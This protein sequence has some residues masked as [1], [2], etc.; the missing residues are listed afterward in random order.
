MFAKRTTLGILMMGLAA[1]AAAQIEPG[2][3]ARETAKDYRELA[4]YPESSRVLKRGE[5]DP[6]RAKRL[7]T[8]QSM[9]GPDGS[10]PILS[11]WTAKISFEVGQ[12]IDLFATLE[13]RAKAVRPDSISGEIADASGAIVAQVTYKDDGQEADRT[14]GDGVWSARLAMPKGLEPSPAASYMVRVKARL[15]DGDLRDGA[16]GFLYSRPSAHLTGRYRDLLRDGNLVVAAEVDVKE[17]GRFHLAG[18][19][20]TAEGEPIGTA[21]SAAHLEPG[22]YWIELS[23]YGLMFHDRKAAGPYRL[24]SLALSTTN[25]MPNAQND[26]VENVHLTRAYRTGQMTERPF[27]E[28]R[29]LETAKRLELDADRAQ[30]RTAPEQQ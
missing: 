23:Y 19:L 18:T 26:L 5:E 24:A 15:A 28:P 11:V 25:V 20:A 17:A 9:P 4:R 10:E 8:R 1:A 6:I 12:P 3:F 27:Q 21:Q 14:A 13:T 22:R 7:P 30:G 2:G 29:L 16:G